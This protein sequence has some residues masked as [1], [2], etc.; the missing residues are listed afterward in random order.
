MRIE[1]TISVYFYE[2]FKCVY[3]AKISIRE[4]NVKFIV[5]ER[6]NSITKVNVFGA[7]KSI[8]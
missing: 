1:C 2:V 3:C 5:V 4:F 8:G 7:V 6:K